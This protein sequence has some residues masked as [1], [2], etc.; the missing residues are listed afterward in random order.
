MMIKENH[1]VR[2]LQ[3]MLV[4]GGLLVQ[5]PGQMLFILSTC[6]E[7]LFRV[8]SSSQVTPVYLPQ[9]FKVEMPLTS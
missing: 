3:R 1:R 4:A 8:G 2:G 9:L 5:I 7:M 6:A